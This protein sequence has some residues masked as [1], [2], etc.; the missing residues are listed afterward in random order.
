[1]AAIGNIYT[2]WGFLLLFLRPQT[3]DSHPSPYAEGLKEKTVVFEN[4]NNME[5]AN[6]AATNT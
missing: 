3:A 1:M 2:D 5:I 6:D 4:K